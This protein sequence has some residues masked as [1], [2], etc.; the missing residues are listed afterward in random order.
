M[1]AIFER[2]IVP[3]QQ[4]VDSLHTALPEHHLNVPHSR[5][6]DEPSFGEIRAHLTNYY[7][8]VESVHSFV[9]ANGSVFDCI[10]VEKQFS[11]RGKEVAV[12]K[13]PDL[14][15][16]AKGPRAEP[17]SPASPIVQLHAD[18]ADPFGNQ[19]LAPEGTIPVRRL[20][21]E[22]LARFR[23][24]RE[25]FQK[26]PGGA[27]AGRPPGAAGALPQVAATHR[28]A[29]AYQNVNNLGGGSFINVWD[30]A[31]GANQIFS[32]AQHWYVGG[33]GTGLQTAECGW[34]VYPQLYGNT[35]PVFFIYWTADDYRST[36]CYNLSC[37]AFVQTNKNWAIGGAFAPWSVK[38]G[39][40]YEIDLAY[41]L[42]EGHWWLYAGGEAAANAVGYYPT[43][44]YRGGALTAHASEIDHGGEVVGTSS[45]PP[46][47]GGAFASAGW[48]HAA[49][50]RQVHYFP[51]GGGRSDAALTASATSPQ[52][53]TATVTK[54]NAPWSETVWFGGPGGGNC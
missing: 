21:L 7:A 51:T 35:K 5:I 46:M 25:F 3:F 50:H 27:G 44:I 15:V 37:N 48:Q 31:I 24:L 34:Q 30:P 54:Y 26:G 33:S 28:W 23:N 19:M 53:Y 6:A 10:P 52:C 45:W 9:D 41:Y 18:L 4:F 13:P 16:D 22:N 2:G 14:P 17:P 20:T 40:Q 11:L 42:S 29:H 43:S 47:G 1:A 49:Y 32:L 39:P 8:G 38:G 12:A 36:G